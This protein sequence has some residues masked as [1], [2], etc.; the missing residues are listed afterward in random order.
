MMKQDLQT[1]EAVLES[2]PVAVL[3]LDRDL[4]ICATNS[5][6]C[7][8]GETVTGGFGD[9]VG[10]VNA[11]SQADGCGHSPVCN[12]CVMRN[13]AHA[14]VG[15]GTVHQR[16]IHVQSGG[17]VERVYIIS[18][19]PFVGAGLDS[20]IRALLVVEDVTELHRMRGLIP[21]CA[22]CKSIRRDDEAWE[23]LEQ[24]IQNHSHALFT[25]SLCPD[26]LAKLYPEMAQRRRAP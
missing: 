26:C 14:A 10:C 12:D 21:I 1:I 8:L 11:V 5:A 13:S 18:A 19:A 20:D 7:A 24:Y 16:E 23:Q 4:R 2:M 17:M 25:H 9:V 3:A 15:G 6:A 22:N